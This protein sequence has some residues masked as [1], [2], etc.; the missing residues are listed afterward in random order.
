MTRNKLLILT[1]Y[2][3]SLAFAVASSIYFLRLHYY[4]TGFQFPIDPIS[5]TPL[6][7]EYFRETSSLILIFI[8]SYL[9]GK[10]FREKFAS[11]MFI[12]GV[13]D[14]F[15][16]VWL[17]FL[18]DWPPSILTWDLLY[19]IPVLWVG[20]VLA[21]LIV[22]VVLISSALIIFYFENKNIRLKFTKF[23]WIIEI[24]SGLGVILSFVWN[25]KKAFSAS[26]L[27]FPWW[28]FIASLII[29]AGCF[30]LPVVKYFLLTKQ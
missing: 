18:L 27:N 14:I 26:V 6:L 1:I 10:N 28:L 22:C 8:A 9:I 20:P 12:F 11:F 23:M 16:Y 13:W 5:G 17:Y 2:S 25:Y 21:P 15:Y 30:Y 19:V 29:G 4:P 7:V 24:M 3:T